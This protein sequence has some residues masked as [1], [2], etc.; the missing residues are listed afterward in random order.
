MLFVLDVGNTN[1]VLGVFKGGELTHHWR[2]KTDRYKTEDEFGILITSLFSYEGLSVSDIDGI[3][4]SSVVP[5]VMFSLEK[6]CQKY[7]RIEPFVVGRFNVETGLNMKY[8]NPAEIGADRIVNAVGALQEHTPPFII[9]DF[10]TATTFCYID[11]EGAYCGGAIAPGINISTEALYSA[12]AKLPKIEIQK[13]KNIIG[14]STIEAMQAGIFY[15]YVAQVDGIVTRMKQSVDKHPKVIATGGLAKL[16][17]HESQT[18]EIVDP[19]LTLK[20]LF[21]IYNRNQKEKGHQE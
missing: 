2:M 4:I 10:G 17:S 12:A 6:M 8:P 16:I 3:V 20:G 7:F 11:E 21:H 14:S 15:G 5:P 9:I 1:A 18:I 19:F 13:P